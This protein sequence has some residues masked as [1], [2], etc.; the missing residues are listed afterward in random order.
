[1]TLVFSEV[2]VAAADLSAATSS[3]VGVLVLDVVA[4]ADVDVIRVAGV[5]VG[6]ELLDLL[7]LLL[8]EIDFEVV[9]IITTL[10]FDVS[11][12]IEAVIV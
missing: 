3:E 9:A 10:G 5:G 7:E 6:N 11:K 12:T 1:M 8:V 2:D 4:D